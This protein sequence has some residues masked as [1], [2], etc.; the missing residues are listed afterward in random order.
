MEEDP[1]LHITKLINRERKE[2]KHE[3][4]KISR[5]K[6]IKQVLE[7]HENIDEK[8]DSAKKPRKPR[9]KKVVDKDL[10]G[11]SKESPKPLLLKSNKNKTI[12][13]KIREPKPNIV[14]KLEEIPIVPVLS[15]LATSAFEVPMVT[16]EPA[17]VPK[18]QP[19]K[20]TLKIKK[21]NETEKDIKIT[22]VNTIKQPV[23]DIPKMN[24]Q[25][26]QFKEQGISILEAL[27]EQEIVNILQFASDKYYNTKQ[28]ELTD[29]EY[30]IIKEYLE[31]IN[32]KHAFHKQVGAP[33]AK[34]KVTLPYNMPSMDKIKPDTNALAKY[35]TTY[36]GP[37]VLSCKLDGV[38]G[39]YSTETSPVKLYTRGDGVVGQD[40]T[41]LLGSLRLPS[42]SDI[43]V[44][45]E[46]I[47]PR[48]VFD[49][50][51]KERFANPRNLVSGI[52]NSKSIDDKT[53]D[54]HFVAYEVIKPALKPSEQLAKLVEWGFEV[55]RNETVVDLTN[56]LLSEKLIDWRTHY[57]YEIDGVIVTND[58]IYDRIDGNPEH[59][60]AF[61]MVISDQMAE[62]KVVD[63]IWTASKSG[64]LKPR[65]RIEPIRLGGVTIEYATGFNGAFIETNK[66]GIG[67]VIQIIR[68]GDVIPHIK[69]VTTPAERA[70]M[71][72]VPYH[73]T[74]THVDVVL[75]N[76][77]E[78]ADVREKNI[79]AFF[80][81]LSVDGLSSGNVKR[82]I[83]SGFNTIPVILKMTRVDF[84]KVEGFGEKM[85]DKVHTGIREKVKSASLIDIMAASN[86]FGR[87]IG[88]L[89]IKPIMAAFPDILTRPETVEQKIVML[90]TIPGIGPE[91][92]KS[93]AEHILAFLN[94][95]K[96]CDLDYKLTG[97]SNE[98]G[99]VE[100]KNELAPVI[101]DVSHP[102]YQKHVVMTKVRD[103]T[104]I[105]GLKRVGGVL[106]D[107]MG[108]NTFALIVKSKADVSNKTKYAVEHNIPMYTPAEF[109]AKYF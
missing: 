23:L 8:I 59:A 5:T 73:W 53:S 15:D 61:K 60:F 32:P 94:F 21:K 86:M 10:V 55:V 97:T 9:T 44:R 89:K 11:D 57:E 103:A 63:V 52:I 20:L 81:S 82:I 45:G 80:T 28:S 2:N 17:Q 77:G 65:V 108:R 7:I 30:D 31:K 47:M 37:Y 62:A 4:P 69:S 71:P 107:N 76:I 98:T 42:Q 87:G 78:D 54:L 74:E 36:A 14:M 109:I 56:E 35:K 83:K 75:D 100:L 85:I 33:I 27:S 39:M 19:R 68:S 99:A 66:I 104:I 3:K 91:N 43:V 22:S 95:L 93:F 92:A 1:L 12:K 58:K 51:Y 6:K 67:A 79:T 64:Y 29:N 50:K 25:I 72:L 24:V 105:D 34:N 26:N 41:H 88:L 106:D 49:E 38:S 84:E 70:K 96:E 40:I 18:K 16:N 102:L 101:V 13:L 90:R 48:R 46:F